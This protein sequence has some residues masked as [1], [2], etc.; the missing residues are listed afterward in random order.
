MRSITIT[1]ESR[2]KRGDLPLGLDAI[3][4]REECGYYGEAVYSKED[5]SSSS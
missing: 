5:R 3:D 1:A 2:L 4:G